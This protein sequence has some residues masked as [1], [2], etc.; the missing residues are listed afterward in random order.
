MLVRRILLVLVIGNGM[1]AE[2]VQAQGPTDP[3]SPPPP[4]LRPAGSN[5]SLP[6]ILLPGT[7]YTGVIPQIEPL[8]LET[9]PDNPPPHEGAFFSIPYRIAPPDLIVIDVLETLSGRPIQGERLVRPDGSV[10]LGFYGDI[11]V[12]GLTEV[13]VKVKVIS[14]LRQFLTDWGL[15]LFAY[16]EDEPPTIREPKPRAVFYRAWR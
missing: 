9:I 5:D 4:L 11:H 10:S 1:R 3:L 6:Q 14:H 16:Q 7:R 15:G 2:P 12:D 13:Q 8:P